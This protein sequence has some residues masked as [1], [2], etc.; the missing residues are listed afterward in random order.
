M[1]Q[2][3]KKVVESSYQWKVQPGNITAYHAT[4]Q[5]QGTFVCEGLTNET[6]IS[7]QPVNVTVTGTS[8]VDVLP[9]VIDVTRGETVSMWC[10]ISKPTPSLNISWY[11]GTKELGPMKCNSRSRKEHSSQSES[12]VSVVNASL[13]IINVQFEDAGQY[14]CEVI[15]PDHLLDAVTYLHVHT[16]VEFSNQLPS[17][18]SLDL[19]S[20]LSLM[21]NATGFPP[22]NVTWVKDGHSLT[23]GAADIE[24]V[25]EGDE[26]LYTCTARNKYSQRKQSVYVVVKTVP[27]KLVLRVESIDWSQATV[28]W[29]VMGDGGSVITCFS[30][31]YVIYNTSSSAH[32]VTFNVSAGAIYR[33][34][35]WAN[36]RLGS[37]PPASILLRTHK[38]SSLELHN[39]FL[40]S[41]HMKRLRRYHGHHRLVHY[42]VMWLGIFVILS[43]TVC[44]AALLVWFYRNNYLK[45]KAV[46]RIRVRGDSESSDVMSQMYSL[47]AHSRPWSFVN[48]AFQ[49]DGST[50]CGSQPIVGSQDSTR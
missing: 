48:P 50:D 1:R 5:H 3:L 21:C 36:N 19:G 44:G 18:I 47:R 2:I 7:S 29:R 4:V 17:A 27:K 22:P 13:K 26:G 49:E 31:Y 6:T 28:G 11:F 34:V 41:Q 25:K 38:S 16:L 32:P 33:V 39:D 40:M 14:K 12:C 45:K 37:G 30:F 9:P 24:H 23:K 42:T 8:F 46:S 43:V 10:N 20:C 35:I 15:A